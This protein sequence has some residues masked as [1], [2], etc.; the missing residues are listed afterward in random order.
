MSFRFFYC[1]MRRSRLSYPATFF[2]TCIRSRCSGN[3]RNF[4]PR[5]LQQGRKSMGALRQ[6]N[7]PFF[8]IVTSV[9]CTRTF[10]LLFCNN[11]LVFPFYSVILNSIPPLI[12]SPLSRV[13]L[14]I[15]QSEGGFIMN[16]RKVVK[17]VNGIPA[18]DGAGVKLRRIIGHND[19][20]DFDPFLMLDAF[21]SHNPSDYIAGFP[22]HPHRGIET[23][24]YLIAGE[25]DHEDSLHN[26]GR[27]TDGS[28][29]WMT[30]GGGILHQEMP[31]ASEHMFGAQ[32][33][34]NLPKKDKMTVPAYND[35]KAEAVIKVEENGA[36]V[37]VISGEYKGHKAP[38]QGNFVRTTYLDVALNSGQEWSIETSEK[39]TVFLYIVLGSL[40]IGGKMYENKQAILFSRDQSL[41]VTAGKSGARFLFFSG[42]PLHEPIAWAGPIVMNTQEELD[43]AFRELQEGTFIKEREKAQ[44]NYYR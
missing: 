33:W 1:R 19:V 34:I 18:E 22:W 30:A 44:H 39:N 7:L 21:D 24:T 43:E 37:A 10:L 6:V 38:M 26:K 3:S 17:T 4:V 31:Q 2:I 35:I 28:C 20:D 14:I 29:Q 42:K 27:I 5:F 12:I 9:Y 11:T 36:R 13:F 40:C 16:V 8:N 41:G 32:L 23:V 25:I 15:I